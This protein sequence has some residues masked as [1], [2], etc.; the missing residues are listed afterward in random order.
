[1]P[2]FI[3]PSLKFQLDFLLWLDGVKVNSY[4]ARQ[5]PLESPNAVRQLRGAIFGCGNGLYST[6][7]DPVPGYTAMACGFMV[8]FTLF[9][10]PV[11]FQLMYC[12]S[13]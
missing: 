1:M 9:T 11:V 4:L 10:L 5:L 2:Y 12:W 13:S 3:L 6:G 7:H 8:A